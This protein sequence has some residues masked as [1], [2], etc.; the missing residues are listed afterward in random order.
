MVTISPQDDLPAYARML[1]SEIIDKSGFPLFVVEEDSI[2]YDSQ[3][4]MAGQSQPFHR[5][6]YVSSYREQR[7]HFLV[8]A[9][10]KI[11]RVW[12]IPPEER[13]IPVSQRG[14]RLP[15]ACEDELLQ[16]LREPPEPLLRGLSTFLYEGIV[17]Q[18]TSMPMDLRVEREIA[19]MLSDHREA[20]RAYLARQVKDLEAHFLPAIADVAPDKIYAAS[21]AMNV[22]LAEEA[23]QIAGVD[24]GPLFQQTPH[25]R[26]G[27]QLRRLL[28]DV[29]QPGYR[30][31]RLVTDA[32][33]DE[34][35][36]RDWYE[37]RRLDEVR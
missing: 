5:L 22:V 37:W 17:R 14:K 4:T 36:L 6:T 24:P 27:E 11:R 16:K 33:A 20:Q 35:G 7:L 9:A 28:L 8:N 15:R 2:G 13:L 12:T 30:G 32:W 21:T 26:F 23:A 29:E 3:L 19:E 18:L 34:L 31:D 1:V 10:F 25:R